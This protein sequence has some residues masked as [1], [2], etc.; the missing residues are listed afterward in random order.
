MIAAH[1]FEGPS[2]LAGAGLT[3]RERCDGCS[4]QLSSSAG[5]RTGSSRRLCVRCRP[6]H[7]G[8]KPGFLRELATELLRTRVMTPQ[9]C[10]WRRWAS[11]RGTL[12]ARATYACGCW[13]EWQD[14]AGVELPAPTEDGDEFE[15]A[16]QFLGRLIAERA[17][18]RHGGPCVS[19]PRDPER[20][21][22]WWTPERCAALGGHLSEV[23]VCPR[24]KV[25]VSGG[26]GG[27]E[28]G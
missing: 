22:D 18:A 7:I 4:A 24:C 12:I 9:L 6:M 1:E 28:R 19:F 13:V 25:V 16:E 21:R 8:F 27:L 10:I 23:G 20:R 5:K 11:R 26:M 15:F 2:A 17:C 3:E 14:S